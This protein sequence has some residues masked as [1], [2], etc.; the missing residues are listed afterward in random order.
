MLLMN[1]EID[2]YLMEGCGRCPLG[3]TTDCKVHTWAAE[4][5]LLRKLVLECGLNEELKWG[6][7][8]YTHKGHN[9]LLVSAFKEYCALSFFKGTLLADTEGILK[10]PGKNSQATRLLKFTSVQEIMELEAVLKAY[11][12]EAIEVEKAGL[13][14]VFKKNP[15]PIPEELQQKL[16]KDPYFRTSFESLTPGRQRGYIIFFSQ[17]KLSKTRQARIE[18]YTS[19]ILNGQGLHDAYKRR[20]REIMN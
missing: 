2:T 20:A 5:E 8:C 18:T 1:P 19:K 15:E 11:V 16:D 10:A 12:F 17:A 4:L 14:V 13:K 3:G 9:I 7:P 6:V